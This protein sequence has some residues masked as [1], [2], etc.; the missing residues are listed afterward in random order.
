M[1]ADVAFQLGHFITAQIETVRAG[2]ALQPRQMPLPTAH[3]ATDKT[4]GFKHTRPKV[5]GPRLLAPI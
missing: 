1:R 3:A 5:D 2:A 4:H